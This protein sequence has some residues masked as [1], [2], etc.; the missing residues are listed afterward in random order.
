MM[1]EEAVRVF[2]GCVISSGMNRRSSKHC[3]LAALDAI[4]RIAIE[5]AAENTLPVNLQQ[6]PQDERSGTNHFVLQH[7][8]SWKPSV[9]YKPG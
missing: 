3:G 9:I 1:L 2:E 8:R 5:R 7:Q 6:A 4:G